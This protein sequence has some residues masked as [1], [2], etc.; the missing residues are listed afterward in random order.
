MKNL[1]VLV[2]FIL[3]AAGSTFGQGITLVQH[4][5]IDA[6]IVTSSMLPFV[7]ATSQGNWLAVC[8]RSGTPGESFTVTDANGTG[9]RSAF[10]FTE[11]TRGNTLGLFYEENISGGP[12]S[13]N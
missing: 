9:L 2:V 4:T 1:T 12:D 13:I 7:K 11:T 6:G 10:Q 3:L 5:S 8:I